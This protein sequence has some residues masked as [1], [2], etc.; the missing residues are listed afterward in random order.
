MHTKTHDT[1]ESQN[2]GLWLKLASNNNNATPCKTIYIYENV[3]S[4]YIQ[5]YTNTAKYVYNL[6]RI[7]R[8]QPK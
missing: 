1:V 6:Q 5:G 8:L 3:L 4:K 2:I 7:V